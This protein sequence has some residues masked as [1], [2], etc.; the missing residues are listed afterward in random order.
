MTRFSSIAL[1]L[2]IGTFAS[3]QEPAGVLPVGADGKAL[4]LDFET[5]T[6]K[7]WTAEGK[8]FEGQPIKGDTVAK[9][10]A[11][12]RS[13][14]QGQFWI[15]GFEKLGDKPTG[16]LTSVPF[17]ITHPWASFLVGGGPW[18][19]TCVEFVVKD[20]LIAR[21]SGIEEEN[22]RRVV[23]DLRGYKDQEMFIRIVDKHT[24]HWGHIN[25]DDFRF[26]DKKPNVPPRPGGLRDE[27]KFAGLS[28][29]KAAQAMTLPEGFDVTL[30][31]GEPD[32]MQPI[33]L[34]LD[35]RG[36]VWVAEA[37]SYPIRRK[38]PKDFKDRIVI[39]E[40][41]DGDGK[42]DKRTVFM[43]GLNLVSGLEVGFGG[44]WIGAAPHLMYVP[45]KE[46]PAKKPV[47]LLTPS[48]SEGITG[49][50]AIPS[51][52]LRVSEVKAAQQDVKETTTVPA[53]PPKILLD[54]WGYQDTHET[55]N[56]FI[57]GPDGW[58]YGCHGVFTH[59]K[60]GKPGTPDKERVPLNAGVWRYHPTRHKFEVFAHGTSNPWGLDF[61]DY[62]Q[63]FVSACVIPHAFHI[64]QGG[65]YHRQAGSHF[66]PHTYAD[67]KTI[68]DHLHW[69][70]ANPWAGNEKSDSTGGGHAHCGLMCYLGGTWPA[71]YRGQLFMGN[72]HGRRINMDVLR[73]KGSGY[74]AS[75]G[76]DFLHANDAWARFI[77]M[78][79][80]PD[81]NVYVIDW[82][83][84]QACHTG[85]IQVWDRSNGR[86]YKISHRN[87]QAHSRK[88]VGIDLQKKTDL[89]L[90]EYQLHEND[91][92]VRHARRIL[93]ERTS[94][95]AKVSAAI[96]KILVEH[97]GET[98]RLRALWAY[99][100]QL[101]EIE[102]IR[103]SA[104][105]YLDHAMDDK[106]PI[107]RAWAIQLAAQHGGNSDLRSDLE[108]ISKK[109][110]SAVVR[111]YLAS[112]LQKFA[113]KE[114][115][116]IAEHLLLHSED[117]DDQNLPLMYWYAIEPLAD[118]DPA[119]ALALA[120]NGKI[121]QLHGY[122][123]RRIGAGGDATGLLIDALAKTP[124]AGGQLTF[125][126]A[127]REALKGR[128]QV[129]M[130]EA[131]PR[132][133]DKLQ[134]GG[135]EVREQAV[136]LAVT[137]GNP[138]PALAMLKNRK[139]TAAQALAAAALLEAGHPKLTPELHWLLDA[140]LKGTKA[141]GVA[142]RGLAAYD[143]PT[144]PGIIFTS[145]PNFTAN[146]KIDAL[147]TLASRSSYAKALLDAV[148]AK[149]IDAKEVSIDIVRQMRNLKDK[150]VSARINEVWGVVRDS[151]AD[152][153]KA[154]AEYKKMLTTPPATPPDLAQGRAIF[155]KNCAQCH[156]LFGVGAKL[157]PDITGANRASLDYLLENILDPSAVIP[158][159]YAATVIEMK[160]GRTITG[161]I[162][163]QTPIAITIG[164][165][166]DALTLPRKE[167]D[168][169]IT[170]KVSMMPDDLLKQLKEDEVRALIAYLQSPRQVE[171][172]VG[173]EPR[174]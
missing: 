81:G 89:E 138:D 99:H 28:P 61:N 72:V 141:R 63:A 82:Y 174:R 159:E 168:V 135:G 144:T 116:K 62:G 4:N 32:V 167:I 154:I 25:F 108:Q 136:C 172:K 70:G 10:R 94:T 115:W 66:N 35:D 170:S 113:P 139:S 152:R 41:T 103:R 131:W 5:G 93:Q 121:P 162:R 130:P 43:E 105:T 160:D 102:E 123:I 171:L 21:V 69:Q 137:F 76:K 18:M 9:R 158:K 53:G 117:A 64:I 98:R 46:I 140:E 45:M 107:V 157:G 112:A 44:V 34:A 37:Y 128:R 127:L 83:D 84:K 80:G 55:L 95:N 36:R 67:I 50:P 51:L 65:R 48:A 86:I 6:L 110:P 75:H 57:W 71:E 111:L 91:W 30:F 12:N 133:F 40:D 59:S 20:K 42:F 92:Y 79:Y 149:K 134:N 151:S 2:L 56:A 114:R 23:V 29:Q 97:K 148:A 38:D 11:D 124:D 122:M 147:H 22:L 156:T 13:E 87:T 77:N 52:A 39:F 78:R 118:V 15:G 16:T 101:G 60:V 166:N 26:H 74:T 17:K 68:A 132:L 173:N 31:A 119:R 165:V 96:R 3:A 33:A 143:D 27:L 73:P 88:A 47:G 19:E 1:L 161:I 104:P 49:R 153:I 58:L 125:L 142:L 129:P 163:A 164:T 85:N 100:V 106:S 146:E 109:E 126:T 7:D 120:L 8:A 145:Y 155:N 24:G 14:H 169:I 54:G 90:V 150:D